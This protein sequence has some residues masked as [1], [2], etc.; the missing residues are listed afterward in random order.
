VTEDDLDA[1]AK[2]LAPNCSAAIIVW[3]NTWAGPFVA[4]VRGS[5]GEVVASGRLAGAD[6]LDALDALSSTT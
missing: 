1:A 2:V 4:A 3:E 6:V 5:G